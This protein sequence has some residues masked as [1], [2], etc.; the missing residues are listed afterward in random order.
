MGS[1]VLLM[2]F[3][4]VLIDEN[5]AEKADRMG[6]LL[7][8]ELNTLPSSVVKTVRGRGLLNAIVIDEKYDAMKVSS[9]N[10]NYNSEEMSLCN[11]IKFSNPYI[12]KTR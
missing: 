11:K 1:E 7:R 6:T 2:V 5:L 4:Q 3:V 8:K 9:L 10:I 12:F